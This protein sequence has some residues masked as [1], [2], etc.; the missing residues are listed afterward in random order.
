VVSSTGR[1]A[2]LLGTVLCLT[3]LS[4][5]PAAVA[6]SKRVF[7]PR[8]RG[9]LGMIPPVN[10]WG[11]RHTVKYETSEGG[12][13]APATYHGGPTMTGGVTVHTIFWG[14]SNYPFVA[15][16]P[17]GSKAYVPLI[18]QYFTDVA[19]ASTGPAG[20][21]CTAAACNAFTVEAQYGWGTTPGAITPGDNTIH[22]NVATDSVI[23]TNPYPSNGCTSPGDTTACLTDPQ[24]QA[25]IDRI[26]QA[27]PGQ[28]RGLNNLWFVFLP[29]NV[30]EC[31][32]QNICG[33]DAFAGYHGLSDVHGHGLT[34]YAI[35]ID[36]IIEIGGFFAGEDPNGN[37]DAE[38]AID[39]AAHEVNEAMTDPE[40]TGWMD[41]N[42]YEVGDKCD[43]APSRGT[44]LGY[45][46]DGSPY[47]QVINGHDYLIQE[48]W[49]NADHSCVQSSTSTSNALPLPQI[50]L[51][52]FS[53]VIS[54]NTENATA[55]IHVTVQLLRS[56]GG[57]HPA[58]VATGAGTTAADGSW[59]AELSGGHALG[60]DR[61]EIVV[62]YS[63]PHA[64]SNDVILTGNGGNPFT[65]SG[66]T[67]WT[68]LD[69]GNALT[70][71][72]PAVGGGPS[73][74]VAGCFQ[75][76]VLTY[77]GV[78]GPEPANYFCGSVTNVAVVPLSAAVTP[79]DR[80]TVT[81]VDNRAFA[82]PNLPGGGNLNGALVSLTVPV[83]EAGAAPNAVSSVLGFKPS[84][85]PTCVADLETG[86]VG[87]DG[88]V[89]G[90]RYTLRDGAKLVHAQA[91]LLGEVVARLGVRE[92]DRVA[93]ANSAR[94]LTTLHVADLKVHL[95]GTSPQV[96]AGHCTP[97]DYWKGPLS[98]APTNAFAG[99]PTALF[100]GSALTG[101]ACPISGNAAG[102]P[103]REIAQTDDRS[104]GGTITN[105]AQLIDISPIEGETLYGKFIAVA[106]ATAGSE[107]VSL[108]ILRAGAHKPVFRARNVNKRRGVAV[109][110]LPTGSYTAFWT[111]RDRNGDTREY[112]SRFIEERTPNSAVNRHRHG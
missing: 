76:G 102:L 103:T 33:T 38:L 85:L 11:T 90:G 57:G 1:R 97:G 84:G 74:R 54:G 39:V 99:E 24:I 32:G 45:A 106:Q 14:P 51:T 27:T 96:A 83:G 81:S 87:C 5:V 9:A 42:G 108:V 82:G 50:H 70:N 111:V 65:L 25:E 80:V 22:Y 86:R 100:G 107:P 95:L 44:P 17:P 63:G 52:Q 93:L 2:T 56:A 109:R 79:S 18:Q 46:D 43:V 6:S 34:I 101:T 31:D 75:V 61:D 28:P 41:P 105:V 77:A 94:T 8:S 4:L 64:P 69:Q 15:A 13:Y 20:A 12:I 91:D 35:A 110:T 40:G 29:P 48:M 10:A 16:A 21:P 36:P 19:A 67:G 26:I 104:G 68:A 73:L 58:L 66:W 60:D 71:H 112:I 3:M 62:S 89:A 23:D 98:I 88:L 7:H 53:G 55:G 78:P 59:S 49:S 47:N 72:D 30:D 92:G 37:P